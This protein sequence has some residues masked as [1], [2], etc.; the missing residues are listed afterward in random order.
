LSTT[1]VEARDGAAGLVGADIVPLTGSKLL[2]RGDTGG[3]GPC[4]LF[5]GAECV[6]SGRGVSK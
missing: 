4:T 3:G 6:I 1:R 2:L 5:M